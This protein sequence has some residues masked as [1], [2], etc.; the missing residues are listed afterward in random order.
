[1]PK[2]IYQHKKGTEYNHKCGFQKGHEGI[3]GRK[4][5]FK[6]SNETKRKISLSKFGDKNPAKR[7]EVRQRMNRGKLRKPLSEEHRRKLSESHLGEKCHFWKDGISKLKIYKHYRNREYIDW[8][9]K[10]FARD[11]WTCQRCNARSSAGNPVIIHPHHIKGYT[12]YP[13]M[14]YI[15]DNGITLCVPCHHRTHWGH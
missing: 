15:V 10:V 2:G 7:L 11:N 12:N 6:C 13:E 14:R 3:G 5:G 9:N 1:M 8:R 4:K